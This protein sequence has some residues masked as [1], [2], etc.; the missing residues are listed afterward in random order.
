VRILLHFYPR[1]FHLDY[2]F[3]SFLFLRSDPLALALEVP[4]CYLIQIW[5][6]FVDELDGEFWP[7][8]IVFVANGLDEGSFWWES[9][10]RVVPEEVLAWTWEVEDDVYGFIVWWLSIG[11]YSLWVE[12][13]FPKACEVASVGFRMGGLLAVIVVVQSS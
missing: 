10:R 13:E 11:R 5:H 3:E 4:F 2:F 1:F 8:C 9:G 7:R 12:G 6:V